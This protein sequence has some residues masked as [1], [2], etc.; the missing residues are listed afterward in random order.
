MNR[1][2]HIKSELARIGHVLDQ[3]D[4]QLIELV[5]EVDTGLRAEIDELA[6]P[7]VCGRDRG[8][9]LVAPPY[10]SDPDE[11]LDGGPVGLPRCVGFVP[12]PPTTEPVL[13]DERDTIPPPAAAEAS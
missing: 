8:E 9:H 11:A 4:D 3:V 13:E 10:A 5:L 2:A 7:C 1:V 6:V 12:K